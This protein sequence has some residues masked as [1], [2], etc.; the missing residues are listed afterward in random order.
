MSEGECTETDM[1]FD[2]TT[3]GGD[4]PSRGGEI[5]MDRSSGV[6]SRKSLPLLPSHVVAES[7]FPHVAG[8]QPLEGNVPTPVGVNGWWLTV[9]GMHPSVVEDIPTFAVLPAPV[10]QEVPTGPGFVEDVRGSTEVVVIWFAP[11]LPVS[12]FGDPQE[13]TVAALRAIARDA[14]R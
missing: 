3:T 1:G 13:L 2:L 14:P 5:L 6:T 11:G 10:V 8:F 4:V 9:P 12:T 7:R